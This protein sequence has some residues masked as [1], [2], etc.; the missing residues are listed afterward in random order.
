MPPL[1]LSLPYYLDLSHPFTLVLWLAAIIVALSLHEFCHAAAA[2]ALGDHTAESEGRLTVNPLVH[3]DPLGLL[4]SV[5]AGFGWARPV[6][7]NPYNLRVQ[8]WGPTLV[9]VAG[10]LSNFAQA[11]IAAVVLHVAVNAGFD[12]T[13][14][15]VAFFGYY[16]FINIALCFFN[17]IPIPPLDGSKFLLD[18]LQG[19]QYQRA[20][21]LLETQGP[22]LLIG[23]VALQYIIG[24]SVFGALFSIFFRFVFFP[25][26]G[27]SVGFY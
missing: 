11:A 17:L 23:I 14:P 16:F 9:A 8:K 12:A 22:M 13:S 15:L 24:I 2:T 4:M 27:V 21:F 3:I 1:F 5:M 7:F 18:L 20:R 10:P 25:L 26:F 6:P 19:P